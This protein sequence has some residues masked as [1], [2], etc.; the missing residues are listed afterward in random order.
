MGGSEAG[1]GK[2]GEEPLAGHQFGGGDGS[3]AETS[4]LFAAYNTVITELETLSKLL[5]DSMEG[6]G[7]AVL[8]ARKGYENTATAPANPLGTPL[9]GLTDGYRRCTST[10]GR[11]SQTRQC[12]VCGGCRMTAAVTSG[13]ASGPEASPARNRRLFRRPPRAGRVRRP[14]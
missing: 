12:H 14:G 7:I 5:S 13:P 8:A 1:P 3:F 11:T 9:N 4:G 6:M 2:V 10:R